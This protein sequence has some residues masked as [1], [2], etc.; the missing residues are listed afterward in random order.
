VNVLATATVSNA[1]AVQ[2]GVVCF[3]IVA[4]LAVVLVFL[5]R[6]MNKQFRKIGPNPDEGDSF[7]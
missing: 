6:S 7:K 3:L 2:T 5:F 4:G 1:N